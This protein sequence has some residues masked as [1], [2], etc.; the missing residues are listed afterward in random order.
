MQL[1]RV[2]FLLS[3]LLGVFYAFAMKT[4]SSFCRHLT[5]IAASVGA[6]LLLVSAGARSR[7]AAADYVLLNGKIFTATDAR[8]Y[9]QA[10]AIKGER[11]VAVGTSEEISSLASAH[12][13]RLDL[14]GRV[15]IPGINDAHYHFLPRPP[16]HQLTLEERDPS[17]EE[18]KKQITTTVA[19]TP[20]ETLINAVIGVA[21]MDDTDANRATLDRLAPN[22][23]VQLACF[24]G[25][26][27]IFNSSFMRKVGI[28]DKEPN[29]PGG[30]YTRD[31]T[32]GLRDDQSSMP[33]SVFT[34]GCST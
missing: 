10:I 5:K 28:A 4:Q 14:Q 24:W 15:V 17:W 16:A 8:P 33:I 26:C 9:V 21:V 34:Q 27:S 32:E 7:D 3:H 18:V 2:A 1:R 6:I 11:I 12:T 29:P 19:G 22:H 31:A 20:K 30:Y 25:H 13:I 23:P